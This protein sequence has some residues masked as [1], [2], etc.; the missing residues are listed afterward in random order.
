MLVFSQKF[1]IMT[2]LYF[3]LQQ[4]V[5]AIIFCPNTGKTSQ[6]PWVRKIWVFSSIFHEQGKNIPI[7]WEICGNLFP[8]SGNCFPHLADFLSKLLVSE[9]VG[10][11]NI[12]PIASNFSWPIFCRLFGLPQKFSNFFKNPQ[13]G[14]D[15][16][17]HRIFPFY[18]NFY[19]RKHWEMH[20][21]SF[22]FNLQGSEEYVPI[23]FRY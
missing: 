5:F 18:G 14:N 12:I 4:F 19:I 16:A 13:P 10:S 22:T 1:M 9:H 21:F 23:L 11:S 20:G 8:I 17:F 7:H 6:T 2:D 3:V 15:M